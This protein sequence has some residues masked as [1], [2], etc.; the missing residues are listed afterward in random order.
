MKLLW[1]TSRICLAC[2]IGNLI[3]NFRM[4]STDTVPDEY[5]DELWVEK[6]APRAFCDLLSDIVR[7]DPNIFIFRIDFDLFQRVSI[8]HY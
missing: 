1:K 3:R 2:I 6:F 7:I 4:E 8:E 5:T